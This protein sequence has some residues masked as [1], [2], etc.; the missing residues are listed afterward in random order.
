MLYLGWPGGIAALTRLTYLSLGDPI[1]LS[2]EQHEEPPAP[3]PSLA[4]HTRLA[5]LHVG[6]RG[7]ERR[8]ALPDLRPLAATLR[9]LRCGSCEG[10]RILQALPSLSHL[11]AL[12]V[13]DCP[14]WPLE[15]APDLSHMNH[16]Q[17]WS[18][19]E[20]W[21]GAFMERCPEAWPDMGDLWP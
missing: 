6:G 19:P 20:W 5:H 9:C 1:L 15:G 8:W 10:G 17:S 21:G 12:H 11:T 7:G 18:V 13:H 16:L 14:P 4:G 2:V 3:P